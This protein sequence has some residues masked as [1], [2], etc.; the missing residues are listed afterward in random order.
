MTERKFIY[1]PGFGAG[2]WSWYHGPISFDDLCCHPVL[3]AAVER[4]DFKDAEG[5]SPYGK[6][7]HVPAFQAWWACLQD[8]YK[9]I[10]KPYT[11]GLRSAEV[12]DAEGGL[13][14]ITEYDGNES[15]EINS[16]EA[17]EWY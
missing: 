3:V 11:G 8:K 9:D 16:P 6:Y 13:V 15:Y 14:R 10:E 12:I 1:S 17:Q 5:S 4:G 2:W 7:E